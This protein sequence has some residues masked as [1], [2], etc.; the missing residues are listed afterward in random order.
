MIMHATYVPPVRTPLTFGQAQSSLSYALKRSLGHDPTDQVLALALAK[1]ALETG[2]WTQ[3]WIDNFGNIKCG[4]DYVGNFTA[5][6]LNEVLNGKLVWFAPEGQL[7]AAP[8]KGGVLVGTPL[9][10][11]DG[12]PQ[13]RMRAYANEF[14]GAISY[15]DFVAGGRYAQAWQRLLAGDAAGYVHALKLAHYFTADEGPYTRGVVSMQSEFLARIR[16]EAPPP[17][18]DLEWQRLV[19][20]VAGCQFDL[21]D[22]I[23]TPTGNDFLEQAA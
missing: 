23:E 2:R 4:P 12:H 22:L 21:A 8:S 14:D 1:T 6:T 5:I 10:V 11:P 16:K 9:P 17:A 19:E 15:L 3:L 13:T 7:T 20:T 18:V